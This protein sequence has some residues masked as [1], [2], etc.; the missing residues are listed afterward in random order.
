MSEEF[1]RLSKLK[2]RVQVQFISETGL[3]EPGIDGGRLIATLDL[4]T[5][6]YD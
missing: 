3:P 1:G 6:P 4:D 2:R 5:Y